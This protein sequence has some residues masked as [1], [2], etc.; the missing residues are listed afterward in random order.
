MSKVSEMSPDGFFRRQIA[1][2][3]APLH[4]HT[5]ELAAGFLEVEDGIE[6]LSERPSS[7]SAAFAGVF[8]RQ[9]GLDEAP[10]GI[11]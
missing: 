3:H 5:C 1:G 7:W 6:N 2:D 11:G 4:S 10:L 8:F 9:K